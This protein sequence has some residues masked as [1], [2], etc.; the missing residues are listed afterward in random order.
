M[1]WVLFFGCAVGG[2]VV[3][4][5]VTAVARRLQFGD[6]DDEAMTGIKLTGIY[7]LYAV[8]LGFVVLSS[9]QF[10]SDG[11]DSVRDEASSVSVIDRDAKSLPDG[12]GVKII[13]ALDQYL[14]VTIDEE[15][16]QANGNRFAPSSRANLQKLTN[17]VADVKGDT[18]VSNV[19][20]TMLYYLG[21]LDEARANRVFFVENEN[22]DF[23]WFLLGFGGLI[24]T[25]LSAMLHFKSAKTHFVLVGSLSA[26]IAVSLFSVYALNHPFTGPFPIGPGPL[27]QAQLLVHSDLAP[28]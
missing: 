18:S 3:G 16:G 5:A 13:E 20:D 9:W 8:I 24:V 12:Q 21:V 10:Y 28:R 2:A 7:T 26:L 27:E 19:Q 22:P 4:L 11:R 15:F 23:M 14:T 17:Q 25:G 6:P 1:E